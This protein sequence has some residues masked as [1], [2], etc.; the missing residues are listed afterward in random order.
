MFLIQHKHN[1]NSKQEKPNARSRIAF[2]FF[3]CH[4]RACFLFFCRVNFRLLHFFH[5]LH[6]N[7]ST[8]KFT[9]CKTFQNFGPRRPGPAN[10]F[11]RILG[12]WTIF[13]TKK[14]RASQRD[15][16]HKRQT[17]G[18]C[19]RTTQTVCR[20]SSDA[21][22][23]VPESTTRDRI[24]CGETNCQASLGYCTCRSRKDTT[25]VWMKESYT[26]TRLEQRTDETQVDREGPTHY[27]LLKGSLGPLPTPLLIWSFFLHP[28]PRIG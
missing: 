2:P 10:F 23:C 1:C 5:K 16:R 11:L 8:Y 12:S 3:S 4:N 26:K 15:I 21:V 24:V 20:R 13:K 7:S 6:V 27:H 14:C 22:A 18:C 17:S 19:V 28:W 9:V 25:F